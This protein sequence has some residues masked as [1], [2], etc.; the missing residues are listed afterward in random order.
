M[1]EQTQ[2]VTPPAPVPAA[3]AAPERP[4][5]LARV[6]RVAAPARPVWET[7]FRDPVTEGHVR[8]EG[9]SWTE[10]QAARMGLVTLGLL[11]VSVLFADLWRRGT[12][13]P[14]GDGEDLTFLPEGLLPVTLLTLLIAWTML[15]WG[16]L[17]SAWPVKL[18]VALAFM[19]TNASLTAPASIEVGE[20]T[21]LTWGP[22][23]VRGGFYVTAGVV[24]LSAVLP[25]LPARLSSR[26]LPVFRLLVLLGLTAFFMTHLW[27]HVTYVDEGF[28]GAVQFLVSNAISEI[29]GLLVPLVYV[30]AVLV[31]DFSVDVAL[32]VSGTIRD[33]PRKF[34]RWVLVALL[35][36]KLWFIVF[37]ELADWAT[38]T[39]DRPVAVVR[40]IVS[41][42]LLALLV[43][44]VSRLSPSEAFDGAKERLLYGTSVALAF[45]IVLGVMVTGAGVF[46]LTQIDN[47]EMPGFVQAYPS[48]AVAD[49]GMPAA[50]LLAILLGVWLLRRRRTAMDTE[51]GSGLVVI[52]AWCLPAL[53]LNL[54]TWE[55]GF[56]DELVDVLVTLG[57]AVVLVRSWNRIDLRL[58]VIL[59]AIT[60]F[61]WLA[62]TK[63]DWI[64]LVGELFALP[65]I[66]VVVV[67]VVF[68]L[69]GDAGFTAESGRIVPQGA[70]VMMFVGY[71]VLSVTIL[72]WVETTHAPS[73]A[74]SLGDAGFFFIG[75]PWAAWV[76][77]RRLVHLGDAP[78]A[79]ES[80]VE[81]EAEPVER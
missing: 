9:L 7:A 24:L 65:A 46:T 52:G 35:V 43:R 54:T 71:L 3:P 74:D 72:H 79:A 61:S 63:G 15:T 42:L 23:L 11:L 4:R 44:W 41:V 36:V 22:D 69:A 56:S 68:S 8:L 60:V 64:N 28:Q 58:T 10:R 37:D 70:R 39:Q 14:I 16:A 18:F 47:Q 40:T 19:L 51:F 48:G 1:S 32:G 29:D 45:P 80:P 55:V 31:I 59:A 62:M 26:L 77:G 81:P 57:V 50:A 33:T 27:V 66:L 34:L 13:L 20:R 67:G 6:A 21:A 76:V 49:Y 2:P 75:I 73:S 25:W 5:P 30:S 78:A 38:Y 53:L 12:L 17:V